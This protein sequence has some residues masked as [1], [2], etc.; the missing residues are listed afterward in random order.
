MNDFQPILIQDTREQN[1]FGLLFKSSYLIEGLPVGDYSIAGLQDRIAIERKSLSDLVG[2]LTHGRERFE[3]ELAKARSYQFFAV[4]VEGS[5]SAILR[6]EFGRS[7]A[8]P[9]VY[10]EHCGI[11]RPVLPVS[12]SR[13]SQNRRSLDRIRFAQIRKRARESRSEYVEGKQKR[14]VLY[15]REG[16]LIHQS[17]R[18]YSE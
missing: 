10:G 3:R 14:P 17:W 6:G 1:G 8:N 9:Q 7:Q 16:D 18:G 11:Q 2:S 15:I 13:R 4:V 5:A 12:F